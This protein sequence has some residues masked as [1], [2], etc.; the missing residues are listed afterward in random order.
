MVTTIIRGGQ[1]ERARE[2]NKTQEKQMLHNIIAHCPLTHSPACPPSM[3]HQLLAN[4][5]QLIY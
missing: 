1:G 5:P 2:R 3:D 4:S